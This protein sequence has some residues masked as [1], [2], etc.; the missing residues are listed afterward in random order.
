MK[1]TFL[2]IAAAEFDDAVTYYESEQP[3]LGARFHSE[4]SRSLKR[5]MD[6]PSAYQ[7]FSPR[8]RR[9]LIAKFPYGI[10]YRYEPANGEVLVVAVAHLHRRPDYWVVRDSQK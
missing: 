7:T 1:V 2:K 8:T 4:V 3:G 9:C 10:I 6:F 5:I